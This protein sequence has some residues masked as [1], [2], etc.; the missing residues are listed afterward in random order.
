MEGR[1]EALEQLDKEVKELNK[2]NWA[3]APYFLV[4][5]AYFTAPMLAVALVLPYRE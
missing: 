2:A 3:A 5:L 4:R 1:K